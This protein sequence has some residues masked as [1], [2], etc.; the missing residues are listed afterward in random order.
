M[1]VME[2]AWAGALTMSAASV[3][4]AIAAAVPRPAKTGR[5]MR[6]QHQKICRMMR[7]NTL[8]AARLVLR[9]PLRRSA[10]MSDSMG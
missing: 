5:M 8:I 1:A 4:A 2:A 9:Q 6:R 7:R 10:Q 3:E